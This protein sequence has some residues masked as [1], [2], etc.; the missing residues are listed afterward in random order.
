VGRWPV[1]L[2]L[3][4]WSGR[5][6]KFMIK[7]DFA[8]VVAERRRLLQVDLS[9]ILAGASSLVWEVGC[10]HG[11]FLAAFAAAHPLS[12]CVGVDIASDRIARAQRKRDRAELGNL[13]FVRAEARL[14][15][16]ALPVG[17]VISDLFILFP[18]PWPKSR[19]HKHR[20]LQRE[21]LAVA[22]GRAAS[23][24]RLY[25]RTDYLP[26]FEWAKANIAN[27][28]VWELADEAWP[29]E[30]ETVFQR[31]AEQHVSLAARL[32]VLGGAAPAEAGRFSG[33]S[34]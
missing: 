4:R 24:C 14:F 32:A 1:R 9:A 6:L 34:F 29:F 10:G 28:A 33:T 5:Q 13:H 30:F 25:F 18:D 22:A 19:H 27:S 2:R 11:H 31:R 17:C 16:E 3:C 20:I 26:Y 23:T 12:V 15:L 7:L 8:D 21:F